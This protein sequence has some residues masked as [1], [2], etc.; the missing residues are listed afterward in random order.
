VGSLTSALLIGGDAAAARAAEA[1]GQAS[2]SSSSVAVSSLA[3]PPLPD[4]V[5]AAVAAVRGSLPPAVTDT[6]RAAAEQLD[7]ART[8]VGD[9]VDQ[10]SAMVP[11]PSGGVV[12][13][14]RALDAAEAAAE[15]GD[16]GAAVHALE[17]LSGY[18][19]AVVR[20]WITAARER[21]AVET[22]VRVVRAEAA[23]RASA[24]Y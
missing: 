24:R 11:P 16:L 15:R 6:A 4:G 13:A 22:V 10:A 20:E 21:L 7:K 23:L 2:S 1:V 3:A 12:S 19:G 5:V 8:A 14:T 17:A 9:A 18:P